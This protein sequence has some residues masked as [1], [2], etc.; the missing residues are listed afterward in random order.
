MAWIV[1]NYYDE[2]GEIYM[3]N[4]SSDY[5]EGESICRVCLDERKE[6]KM[7]LD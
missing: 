4:S 3:W 5:V 1:T 6:Y 7:I 2:N